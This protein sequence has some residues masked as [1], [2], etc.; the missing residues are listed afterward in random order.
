MTEGW[1]TGIMGNLKTE[2][3]ESGINKKME[4]WNDLPVL[5]C[6]GPIIPLFHHSNI[7]GP[8]VPLVQ[9]S[10]VPSVFSGGTE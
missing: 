2:K 4:R 10:I 5:F 7:P 8:D 6:E 9:Y 1:N 3:E